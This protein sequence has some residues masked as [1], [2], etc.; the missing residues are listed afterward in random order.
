MQDNRYQGTNKGFAF[1]EFWS[2][3]QA[4]WAYV[5]LHKSHAVFGSDCAAKV[6]FAVFDK[7]DREITF[8]VH[9]QKEDKNKQR[10]RQRIA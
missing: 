1:L 8:Q 4:T 7:S 9:F 5:H 6:S 10:I 2:L 3:S